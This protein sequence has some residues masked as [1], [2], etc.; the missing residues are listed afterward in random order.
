[1]I[2]FLKKI[3]YKYRIPI[4]P[5]FLILLIF[6][7]IYLLFGLILRIL[8]INFFKLF[9]V[10]A[11]GHLIGEPDFY[12][13]E[14]FLNKKSKNKKIVLLL[15]I[16]KV[17]N[18]Y[19]LKFLKNDFIIIKSTIA[20]KILE[21]FLILPFV[22]INPDK[23][24]TDINITDNI[25]FKKNI[26]NFNINTV[27]RKTF[28]KF[29]IELNAKEKKENFELIKKF[30]LEKFD[31]YVT[32]HFRDYRYRDIMPG[33]RDTK[34]LLSYNDL[35]KYL[36]NEKKLAVI[37]MGR[38]KE[39]VPYPQKIEGFYDY[40]AS[41]NASDKNDILLMGNSKLFIGTNSGLALLSYKFRVPSCY[42]NYVPFSK[43]SMAPY[44]YYFPKLYKDKKNNRL[45]T[46][47]QIV[48][49]D[50][51]NSIDPK[52]YKNYE[53][54]ENNSN[55]ILN[56]V[57]EFILRKDNNYIES[58]ESLELRARFYKIM[59]NKFFYGNK[60]ISSYFL[61]KYKNLIR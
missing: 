11:I 21:P 5:S 27:I 40:A 61:T 31:G 41:S 38:G 49:S 19:Y 12:I 28:P 14:L 43:S 20:C 34:N 8:K 7:P 24:F 32:L 3:K 44:S 58:K 55:D 9:W 57:K 16:D 13:R 17:A 45:L 29:T 2:N 36:I 39:I 10:D 56:F 46:V 42:L 37:R 25:K 23:Y 48:S 33:P 52:D 26:A 6:F 15:P 54:I 51:F 47:S 4:S 35:I 18:K 59:E 53:V 22:T 30:K 50:I 60:N 1:M